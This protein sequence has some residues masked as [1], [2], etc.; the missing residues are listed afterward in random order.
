MPKDIRLNRAIS[1]VTLARKYS[2][3][4]EK[5]LKE[6]YKDIWDLRGFDVNKMMGEKSALAR[7]S[8][9][10]SK[11]RSLESFNKNVLAVREQELKRLTAMKEKEKKPDGK[12]ASK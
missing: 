8:E 11:I 12:Q 9:M 5:G 7:V 3:S 6:E 1:N 4:T 10:Q 2:Q